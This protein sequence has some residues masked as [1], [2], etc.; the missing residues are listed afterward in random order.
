MFG[1]DEKT[2]FMSKRII[3]T[4]RLSKRYSVRKLGTDD[5][6]RIYSFCASH[7]IYYRYCGSK[8]TREV[9][10]NDLQIT[11]PGISLED[12]YYIGFFE[13]DELIAIMDLINGYPT[14]DE[15]F[16]GFFMINSQYE[17]KELGSNLISE[18]MQYLKMQGFVACRLGIDRDN[19]QSTHFWKKNGFTIEKEIVREHGAILTAARK[20]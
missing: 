19:P 14:D 3:E 5:V 13:E 8:L 10:E 2:E 7:T 11:P 16:I 1:E 6:E 20:I 15:A 4:E 18:L 12:K 17:G 9:I